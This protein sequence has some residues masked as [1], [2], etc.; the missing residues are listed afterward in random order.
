METTNIQSQ[1]VQNMIIQ[2]LEC[3]YLIENSKNT[4]IIVGRY[5][6]LK[7]LLNGNDYHLGLKIYSFYKNYNS[8]MIKGL[9]SY[10]QSYYDKIP[11]QTQ[12]N[13][14]ANPNKS[15]IETL[16][17][18]SLIRAIN[19]YYQDQS[20]EIKLIKRKNAIGKR[21]QAIIDN[22][23]YVKIHLSEC[24]NKSG[25][26]TIFNFINNII[27]LVNEDNFEETFTIDFRVS[28]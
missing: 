25:L 9:E 21:K 2:T 13:M 28:Y 20:K 10:K 5:N 26:D 11:T 12:L 3:V 1:I 4:D 23:E 17:K 18:Q 24:S 27:K 14:I 8:I 7:E 19:E 15:D 6:L 22:C 16:L